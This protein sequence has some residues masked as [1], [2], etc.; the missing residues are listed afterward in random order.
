VTSPSLYADGLTGSPAATSAAFHDPKRLLTTAV[1]RHCG[2]S[3]AQRP[4]ADYHHKHGTTYRR[5]ARGVIPRGLGD[6]HQ[7]KVD[8]QGQP[9]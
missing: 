3:R 7:Q 1:L 2:Y 6:V 9:G 4:C 5:T 8:G